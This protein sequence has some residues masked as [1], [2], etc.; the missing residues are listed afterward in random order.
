MSEDLILSTPPPL[1]WI[2]RVAN[3]DF[4]NQGNGGAWSWQ[5]ANWSCD[6]L[7]KRR[8][9]NADSAVDLQFYIDMQAACIKYLEENNLNDL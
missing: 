9:F 8:R 2:H 4:P 6:V 7:G 5:E 1:E 3:D